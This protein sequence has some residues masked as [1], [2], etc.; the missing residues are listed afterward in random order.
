[1]IIMP[2]KPLTEPLTLDE[3]MTCSRVILGFY[4]D[5]NQTKHLRHIAAPLLTPRPTNNGNASRR[6]T[7]TYLPIN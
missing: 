6:S 2:S 4:I 7:D 1:M 5:N 3:T